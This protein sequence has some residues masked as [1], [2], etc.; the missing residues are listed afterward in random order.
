[1]HAPSAGKRLA[2]ENDSYF[3]TLYTNPY[4]FKNVAPFS[5]PSPYPTFKIMEFW[6]AK[7]EPFDST[8][9]SNKFRQRFSV[10]DWQQQSFISHVSN[11]FT[12][13]KYG[14]ALKRERKYKRSYSLLAGTPIYIHYIPRLVNRWGLKI[15]RLQNDTSYIPAKT[16][17]LASLRLCWLK[18]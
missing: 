3:P 2:S 16:D 17:S 8:L 9:Q 12:F 11:T 4:T 1:M 10:N 18:C 6:L 7:I 5:R 13:L 14:W 15:F